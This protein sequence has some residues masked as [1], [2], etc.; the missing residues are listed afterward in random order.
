MLLLGLKPLQLSGVTVAFWSLDP[1]M[2]VRVQP[3]LLM[4]SLAHP[5]NYREAERLL[6]SQE[7]RV[8]PPM[9]GPNT[10]EVADS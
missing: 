1:E 2:L 5:D 4:L 10:T 9:A 3:Q 7:I 6:V 8:L